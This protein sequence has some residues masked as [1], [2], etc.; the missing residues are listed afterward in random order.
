M[1]LLPLP[2]V[3]QSAGTLKRLDSAAFQRK[4]VGVRIARQ[5]GHC[6]RHRPLRRLRHA[7]R[8]FVGRQLDDLRRIESVFARQFLDRLAGLVRC[9]RA[10]VR[11]SGQPTGAP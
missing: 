3:I 10:D 2:S 6:R 1:S 8:I 4:R 5:I 9:N 7:E 11:R